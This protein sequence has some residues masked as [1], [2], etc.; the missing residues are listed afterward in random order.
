MPKQERKVFWR[1]LYRRLRKEDDVARF[2][3]RTVIAQTVGILSCPGEIHCG[4]CDELH[5]IIARARRRSMM[6]ASR[7][8][9]R[10]RPP[11]L[12]C[13]GIRWRNRSCDAVPLQ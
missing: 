2:E 13:S 7:A 4:N 5:R 12:R 6:S 9:T 10:P 8:R 3:L 11:E 1:N